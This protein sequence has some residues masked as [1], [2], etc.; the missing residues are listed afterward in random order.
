M[1]VILRRL[2]AN[3][4]SIGSR[5]DAPQEEDVVA[6]SQFD[7]IHIRYKSSGTADGPR[8]FRSAFEYVLAFF[9]GHA[10]GLSHILR[11]L[12]H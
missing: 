7:F 11:F 2:L 1:R 10:S 9:L 6:Q 4:V 12:S 3:V 5:T 8:I